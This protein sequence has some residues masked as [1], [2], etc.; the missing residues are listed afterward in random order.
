[1]GDIGTIMD[2]YKVHIIILAHMAYTA[3]YGFTDVLSVFRSCS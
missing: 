3:S 1:M 2:S